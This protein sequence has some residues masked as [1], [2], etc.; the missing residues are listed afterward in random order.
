[1]E[2]GVSEFICPRCFRPGVKSDTYRYCV[3]CL[4]E[5]QAE[6]KARR[7]RK[8]T[9]A[10]ARPVT[11]KQADANAMKGFEPLSQA[12]LTRKLK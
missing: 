2:P 11:K 3:R 6:A 7:E 8:Q 10:K 5:R 12:F 9:G 1:M 4:S